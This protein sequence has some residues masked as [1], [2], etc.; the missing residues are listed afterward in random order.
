MKW[1][2]ILIMFILFQFFFIPYSECSDA[3]DIKSLETHMVQ[4]LKEVEIKGSGHH[5]VGTK[6][7][8]AYKTSYDQ[9]IYIKTIKTK[10][11]RQH[12]YLF[13]EG[14]D[15]RAI[16]W[17]DKDGTP[18]KVPPYPEGERNKYTMEP[19]FTVITQDINTYSEVIP[20]HGLI[21]LMYPT[22]KW[23][24]DLKQ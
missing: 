11:T 19:S 23:I 24:D 20:D 9:W 17:V 18:I 15:L 16:V 7:L 2:K 14:N 1:F 4:K 5:L 3:D 13:K 21:L 22:D 10:D 6:N 8:L 12:V